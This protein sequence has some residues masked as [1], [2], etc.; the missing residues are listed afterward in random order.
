[1]KQITFSLRLALEIV[2]AATIQAADA[3]YFVVGPLGGVQGPADTNAYI[4]PLTNPEDIQTARKWVAAGEH[5]TSA[6][7]LG[8]W[9]FAPLGRIRIGSDGINRNVLQPGAPFWSW[10]VESFSF[11]GSGAF[12]P[13]WP[14][15]DPWRLEELV[16]AGEYE[17][18]SIIAFPGYA[19]IEE[20]DAPLVLYYH[21]RHFPGAIGPSALALY[22]S[23][24]DPE[25][26]YVI[27]WSSALNHE[28]WHALDWQE[29]GVVRVAE[30][31]LIVT[32]DFARGKFFRLRADPVSPSP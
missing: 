16:V 20:L 1:M 15:H 8:V 13:T 25:L 30:R 3:V 14:Y 7:E 2:A 11:W 17:D 24:T 21:Q 10:H 4:M 26:S 6:L 32:P 31:I 12:S 27:E 9:D 22:W 28:D 19:M 5:V 29:F 18:N 23:H